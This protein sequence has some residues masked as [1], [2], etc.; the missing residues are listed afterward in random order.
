MKKHVY[1][2][3]NLVNNK[4]Y[5]GQTNNLKRR[6]SEHINDK[7]KDNPIHR[8]L[9]KYG[10]DNFTFEVLYHGEEYNQK[11]I[12]LI[13]YYDTT[14]KSKGYNILSGGQDSSGE[15]NPMSKIDQ[16]KANNIIVYLLETDLSYSEIAKKLN[17]ANT[18]VNHINV[19]ESWR[20]DN[21]YTYPLRQNRISNDI[22][23]KIVESLK[24]TKLNFTKIGNL[25]KLERSVIQGI[26]LGSTYKKDN[27][28]YPIRKRYIDLEIVN[29]IKDL[30][31]NTS[32]YYKDIAKNMDTTISVVAK[33][34]YGQAWKDDNTVYPIRN[35]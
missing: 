11:E 27:L 12:D 35:K 4:I 16:E 7:R 13:D 26:N 32:L 14:N 19:G 20:N 29:E 31:K 6:F 8:A 9:K 34:N 33:I 30:L 10:K 5:I 1:K 17:I 25:F 23:F 15:N 22:Y 2:I 24:T 28:D 18:F 3:T 21:L